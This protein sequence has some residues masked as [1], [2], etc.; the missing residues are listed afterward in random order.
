MLI[1]PIEHIGNIYILYNV[2]KGI[3]PD[4]IIR[5][6]KMIDLWRMKI[7]QTTASQFT[8]YGEKIVKEYK[9]K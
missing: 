5:K 1:F 3:K 6:D 2:Y 7:F 4:L 8:N 9:L